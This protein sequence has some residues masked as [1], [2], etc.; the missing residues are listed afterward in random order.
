[1]EPRLNNMCWTV[2]FKLLQTRIWFNDPASKDLISSVKHKLQCGLCVEFFYVENHRNVI[3]RS[4]K[5]IGVSPLAEENVKPRKFYMAK[6]EKKKQRKFA[7]VVNEP[8]VVNLLSL[9][10][11]VLCWRQQACSCKI[12]LKKAWSSVYVCVC[13]WGRGGE[14]WAG[15]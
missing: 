12:G 15:R 4:G 14:G 6:N 8:C 7:C 13:V 5:L 11:R 9:V 1:M 2:S 3:I 10:N